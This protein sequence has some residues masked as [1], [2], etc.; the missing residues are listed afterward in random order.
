VNGQ[1]YGIFTK[2][3]VKSL[4]W[5]DPK[6]FDAKGYQVPKTWADLQALEQ[7]MQK[8]GVTPWCMAIDGGAG[9]SWP[10]TDWIEDILLHQAGPDTYDKLFPTH[11]IAWT[12]PAVKQAWQ[13]FGAIIN[14]PKM[15]FGGPTTA[16]ATNF[17]TGFTPMFKNPPGC[18]LYKQADFITTFFTQQNSNLKAGVDYNFF[19]FPAPN[20]QY[21]QTLEVAGDLFGMFKDTPQARALIQY[22]VTPDAQ[23]IWA[24]KGG[25]L[26]PSKLVDPKVYPDDMTRNIYKLYVSAK[27]VRFDGSD[28]MPPAA[29][30]A[31]EQGIQQY[32]GHPDQLDSVLQNIEQQAQG[33][34]SK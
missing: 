20:P 21:Q 14:D 30:T 29:E 31:F 33:A 28:Q 10:A 24:S 1:Q 6:M 19:V 7:Q 16:L 17:G 2:A 11:Q 18:Y 8:D 22:L 9:S 27:N 25:Y 3:S 23:S 4:V 12:D 15:S 32:V 26:A 34:Y 13:T 5:Y